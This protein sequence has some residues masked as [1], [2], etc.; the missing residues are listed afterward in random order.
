MSDVEGSSVFI[1]RLSR[2]FT[3]DLKIQTKLETAVMLNDKCKCV[4]NDKC[5]VK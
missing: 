1:K 4:Q 5:D 3:E 2:P